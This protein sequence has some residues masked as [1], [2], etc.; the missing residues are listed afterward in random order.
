[1]PSLPSPATVADAF[2]W[3]IHTLAPVG[4]ASPRTEAEWLL[5]DLL[6]ISR[7][8][9]YFNR[10]RRLTPA[11]H[12]HFQD[13][14]RRRTKRIP[15]QQILGKAEFFSLSFKVTPRVLIPRP[16]TEV[17]VESLIERL[18]DLPSPR[19]L[20]LGTGSGAIG[21]ALAH[22]LPACEV[23]ASDLST[24]ALRMAR[25]NARLNRVDRSL[26]FVQGDL[27]S[28]FRP[29]P[30]F[31]AIASNPPY[32][33]SGDLPTLQP[34]VRKFEPRAAL[35][36]GPDGLRVSRTIVSQAAPYLHPGGWLA[37]EVGNDQAARV[38]D[39]F[40]DSFEKPET[41]RDLTGVERILLG[42]KRT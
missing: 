2:R 5:T 16:E 38:A 34:E 26:A 8:D 35:D 32:I 1:M 23:V 22:T 24:E 41:I 21:V 28:P 39:L 9:L 27:L 6:C 15:L 3:A 19:I 33:P 30:A 17:L 37:L 31:H 40:S 42:R 36:G 13:A 4:I 11:Q 25:E 10:Q 7:A 20:D 14:V 18:K 12:R 29:R